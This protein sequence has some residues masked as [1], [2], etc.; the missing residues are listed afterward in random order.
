[1]EIAV[2]ASHQPHSLSGEGDD[3]LLRRYVTMLAEI[4]GQVPD[5]AEVADLVAA[6]VQPTGWTDTVDGRRPVLAEATRRVDSAL[7]VATTSERACHLRAAAAVGAGLVHPGLDG[8]QAPI[9]PSTRG[10][11]AVRFLDAEI[12]AI[13]W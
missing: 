4:H 5:P 7:G 6:V 13:Y 8:S 2:D 1:M 10:S 12:I 3:T 9:P 11:T